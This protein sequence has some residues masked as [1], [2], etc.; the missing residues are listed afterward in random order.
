MSKQIPPFCLSF[1]LTPALS[2]KLSG[3]GCN[4]PGSG[5]PAST[6]DLTREIA[7]VS[8]FPSVLWDKEKSQ[9]PVNS[10]RNSTPPS[11]LFS[12]DEK[13]TRWQYKVP[14]AATGPRDVLIPPRLLINY[15][16]IY[17]VASVV[18]LKAV[19]CAVKVVFP[20]SSCCVCWPRERFCPGIR[21]SSSKHSRQVV[22]IN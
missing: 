6:Y 8:L 2:L 3:L 5:N 13:C 21:G 14:W 22:V 11:A 1:S 20:F 16:A 4:L 9:G 12:L 19:L 10:A 17:R 18:E 15:E 7:E